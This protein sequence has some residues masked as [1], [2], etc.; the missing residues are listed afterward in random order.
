MKSMKLSKIA[1]FAAFL[2]FS[3]ACGGGWQRETE[4]R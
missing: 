2:G 4:Q 1:A 3:A